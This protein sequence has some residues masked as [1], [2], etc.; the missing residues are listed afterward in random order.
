M[1]STSSE[2]KGIITRF[3]IKVERFLGTGGVA[4][5]ASAEGFFYF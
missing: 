5:V 1:P 4:L 3:S 2:T